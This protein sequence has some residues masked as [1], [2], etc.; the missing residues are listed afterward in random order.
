ML[1]FWRA[2]I[3]A[4]R[5]F[6]VRIARSGCGCCRKQMINMSRLHFLCG[7]VAAMA[8]MSGCCGSAARYEALV[9]APDVEEAGVR[10]FAADGAVALWDEAGEAVAA[11][12]EAAKSGRVYAC[13]DDTAVPEGMLHWLAPA[14]ALAD[15]GC[16]ALP[17]EQEGT[18]GAARMPY[19]A[20]NPVQSCEASFKAVGGLVRLHFVTP[21]RVAEAVIAT[22]DSNRYM[23][24]VFEMGNYPYPVLTPTAQSVRQVR[25]TGAEAVDFAQGGDLYACIA[26]GCYKTLSV[27]LR[28]VDGRTCVKELPEGAFVAIDRNEMYTITLGRNG[29]ELVFE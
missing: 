6:I 9:E 19:Y 17:S 27:M 15:G 1:I 5:F 3:L 14:E 24:G 29:A 7:A 25:L 21:E 20:E 4:A 11:H 10:L 13:I 18:M 28:L 12:L 16:V 26:P 23:A 8:L 22:S 2:A